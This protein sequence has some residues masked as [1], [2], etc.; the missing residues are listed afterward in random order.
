MKKFTAITIFASVLFTCFMAQA[1]KD[2]EDA[3]LN[4]TIAEVK[5]GAHMMGPEVKT[6]DMT[7]KVVA[8]VKWGIH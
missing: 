2:E 6:E 3:A 7:G 1:K 5:L 4:H 8:I